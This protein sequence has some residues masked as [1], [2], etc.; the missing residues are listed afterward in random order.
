[1]VRDLDP[2]YFALV[3][4][5][6][7]VSQA[8]RL[9][10]AAVVAAALFWAGVAAFAVLTAA[11]AWRLAACRREFLADARDPRRGFGYFTFGA[12]AAVLAV[13]LAAGAHIPAAAALLALG[14][15]AWLLLSYTLPLLLG[16]GPF[17]Q[18]ELAGAN[19]T[20]F[21]WAVGAQSAAVAATAFPRPVP[22]PLSAFGVACW[23]IGVVLYLVITVLVV[24]ARMEFPLRPEEPT[25]PYWVFMGA[26]AISVLAGSQILRLPDI[27]LVSSVRAVVSGLSVMLWAFGTWLIPLLI[28]LGTWRHL[29]RHVPLAYEVGLWSVVFPVGMYGVASRQLGT[30][31]RVPW[32]VT[33]GR[34]E[35][36]AALASWIAV[37]LTMAAAVLRSVASKQG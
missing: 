8:M 33:L 28:A 12:A 24:T 15:A 29:L 16:S 31:L 19:G 2:A 27:P 32:L 22:E 4:A 10:N 30:V 23:A 14:A 3:M 25:G 13:P 9:D 17:R 7:I 34:Y 11:Y 35:A 20:W 26:T 6:G 1:V 21:V 5:T 37:T 36:W 18:P